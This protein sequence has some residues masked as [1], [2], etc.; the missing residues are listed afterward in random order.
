M[1]NDYRIPADGLFH[2]NE[3]YY[4]WERLNRTINYKGCVLRSITYH[5]DN[6]DP[7]KN[8]NHLEWYVTFP[9]G[10]EVPG[11]GSIKRGGSL[12]RIKEYIDWGI[13]YGKF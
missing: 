7:S 10:H 11:F 3:K 5:N 1:A 13:K 12:K 6:W 8:D 4:I 9:D 2:W